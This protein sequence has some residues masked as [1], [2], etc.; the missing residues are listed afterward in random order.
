MQKLSGTSSGKNKKVVG[1]FTTNSK[2]LV[3]HFSDFPTIFYAIYKKQ[4]NHFTIG[5]TPLQKDPRKEVF[6]CNVAPGRP[7]GAVEHNSGEARRSLA[8][9]GWGSELGATRVRFGGS[10]GGKRRLVG[11][12][13]AASGGGRR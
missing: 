2:K 9:G 8:G 11:G 3:L 6:F 4:E 12:A 1:Y 13:P 5:V 7:A 10:V